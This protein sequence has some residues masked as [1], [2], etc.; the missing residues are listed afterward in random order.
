MSTLAG[1]R[2]LRG[3]ITGLDATSA[4]FDAL[5]NKLDAL[6]VSAAKTETSTER[7]V[8]EIRNLPSRQF[9]VDELASIGS[10]GGQDLL[11]PDGGR[12]VLPRSRRPIEASIEA[13]PRAPYDGVTL[14]RVGFLVHTTELVNH[15]GCVW[16]LLPDEGA[17][18]V[19]VGDLETSRIPQL[20]GCKHRV[21]TASALMKSRTRYRYLVSNHPVSTGDRPLIRELGEHNI[22][23]MYAAGKSGWNLS[24]WNSLYDLI[25]CFGP[26]HAEAFANCTDGIVLQMGYPR[27]DRFFTAPVDRAELNARYGC[28]SARKC[29]V[30]L[31]TW[32]T[33]SSVGLFGDEIGALMNRYNVVVKL[34][35]LMAESE[36]ECVRMLA[37][38]KF[39]CLITDASDNLPLYQLADFM[40]FDY[41]GPPFAGL[42]ADKNMLLLNV[43]G[44]ESD[45]L[46]GP[47][48]PDI[49][50]RRY[51]A[52]VNAGTGS[53]AGLL[54]N[55]ELWTAQMPTRRTLRKRFFAPY[56]G[57]SSRV[58]AEALMNLENILPGRI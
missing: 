36:P 23:F 21:V 44:A 6:V 45:A 50:L 38:L 31:P 3:W 18:V 9:I 32:K 27:F 52:N 42:Y 12:F 13:A 15:F 53:I 34:H 24:D 29:V 57:F 10:G 4:R 37:R 7:T 26:F 2:R 30:W 33:L 49:T 58:A 40:L 39:T 54:E 51:L 43:P 55:A 28:D 20:P 22:R 14:D 16:D 48:S 47:D 1:L 25:L 5:Q 41:G 11:R 8:R 46:T 56:F 35:P 19:L 17:D